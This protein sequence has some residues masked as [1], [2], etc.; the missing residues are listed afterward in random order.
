[1]AFR[2]GGGRGRGR[3]ASRG[4]SRGRGRGRG[5]GR[6]AGQRNHGFKSKD[7]SEGEQF[8]TYKPR[9]TTAEDESLDLASAAPLAYDALL[10]LMR[11]DSSDQPRKKKRKVQE[12]TVGEVEL[13]EEDADSDDEDEAI[14]ETAVLEEQDS[15][16]DP[17]D[18]HFQPED[19]TSLTSLCERAKDGSWQ[20]TSAAT[21]AGKEIF[22]T[23]EQANPMN[24]RSVINAL[25]STTWHL[26]QRIQ[27]PKIIDQSDTL[28]SSHVQ[29]YTS[30]LLQ[31]RDIS[32]SSGSF[33]QASIIRSIYSL[34]VVNHILKT[35]D[36]ILKNNAKLS[37]HP[38]IETEYRDQGFTR[39]KVL[40][41]LP[42]RNACLQVVNEI[43]AISG[44][45]QIE[46]RKRFAEQFGTEG[47]DPLRNANKPE[48][49]KARFAGN[50]DDAF[51]IGVKFTRKTIK[52]FA[53]FYGSD[54][55]VASPLGL[56]MAIGDTN[57]KKRDWD[58]LS[59]IEV[60][61]IDG[62]NSMAMQ[63]WEHLDFCMEYLNLLPKEAHGCDYGR[64]R[65]W[66]LEER[67]RFMR[68]TVLISDYEFPEMRAFFSRL[69]NVAGKLRLKATYKGAILDIGYSIRQ[70][71][72]R[73][74]SASPAQDPDVRFDY[75]KASILPR[76]RKLAQ[77]DGDVGSGCLL[78][79]PSYFDFVRVRNHLT[80][81]DLS[82]EAISEYS[83]TSEL[84]RSRH[85]FASGRSPILIMT[86]R[87]HHYRRYEIKGIRNIFFY[88][89]PEHAEYFTELVRCVAGPGQAK[90]EGE[91][92]VGYSR[93]D[94][95][96][97]ERIVG[98]KRTGKMLAG[99]DSVFE[100]V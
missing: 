75:F 32:Y 19:D 12:E 65:N 96:R 64:V 94:E 4:A 54:I 21:S 43:I 15:T 73:F 39:P 1:M 78:F 63:N 67:S 18:S 53:Q 45:E 42:T 17:F 50:T 59:S 49:F 58:Y 93:W 16:N 25:D 90:A 74:D 10:T 85:I 68:Q 51:R 99:K 5:R 44:A 56:R 98:T 100:F 11:P 6:P 22:Q 34:H 2:G 24:N 91:V 41:L 36:R 27:K 52:L 89:L 88:Q 29:R 97:I 72:Q 69:T 14:L 86:E 38:E 30:D 40:I 57:S 8:G 7:W 46:N 47:V 23:L 3:G 33:K 26:K 70:T 62:A 20:T 84:T 13:D 92:R 81:L 83:S 80:S 28:N 95:A 71:F 61:V 77:A 48:D 79:V 55:I 9:D 82:F 76:L 37:A 66:T 31:Y 87:L 35:R 60:V